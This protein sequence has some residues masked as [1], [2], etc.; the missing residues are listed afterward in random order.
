MILPILAV[1]FA[2]GRRRGQRP[3]RFAAALIILVAYNEIVEQGARAVRYQ[4]ASPIIG[5][6]LPFSVLA[7]F[8]LLE[9]LQVLFHPE[10]RRARAGV[11]PVERC[12]KLAASTHIAPRK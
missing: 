11:R 12:G 3:Y 7:V 1:P 2:L 9:V 5:I 8:A 6:W 10:T 4:D